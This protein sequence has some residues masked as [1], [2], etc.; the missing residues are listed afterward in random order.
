MLD[1]SWK[2]KK[3]LSKRIS[4][5]AVDEIYEKAKKAGAVGG[6]ILGAGGG[7]FILFFVDP[8]KRRNV[9]EALTPLM[10]VPFEFENGGTRVIYYKQEEKIRSN[11]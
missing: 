7:G 9:I 8:E 11:L 4:T 1:Y 2:L 6:K 3:S 5:S 10:H